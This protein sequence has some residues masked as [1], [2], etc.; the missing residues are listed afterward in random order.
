MLFIGIFIAGAFM[1]VLESKKGTLLPINFNSDEECR[2]RGGCFLAGGRRVNENTALA[3]MH[4]A[5]V[6]LH[7]VYAQLIS[8]EFD[9]EPQSF[10]SYLKSKEEKDERIFQESRKI[11]IACLQ[12]IFYEEWLAKL[13]ITLPNYDGYNPNVKAE[14]SQAFIT[15]AFRFGHTLVPNFFPQLTSNYTRARRPLSVRESFFNNIPIF[16]N[17]IEE[18]LRGLYGDYEEAEN[19]DTTFSGS[20]AKTLFIPPTEAGFQNLLAL[21]TQRGRDH[22]LPSYSEYRKECGI[23]DTL[24]N[25]NNPFSIYRNEI[26]DPRALEQLKI[27]YGSPN[28]HVDLFIG[29]MAESNNNNEFLGPTFKCIIR[30][31]LTNLRVG[32]RFFY[33]NNDQFSIGQQ[34]EVRKM[35]LAK[36]MCL[37]LRDGGTIQENLFDVFNPRKQKRINCENLLKDSLNVKQW[38]NNSLYKL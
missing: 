21:N 27:T 7:N 3:S 18:T 25:S 15:A 9:K 6:R 19:F 37:I 5:W 36:V 30:K 13:N 12:H 11:V 33:E 32:D 2:E 22:G 38:L 24:P 1:N 17:G 10:E 16:K 35:T 4:T 20:I 23:S 31:T 26:R 28:N 14:V 8:E 29:G 34:E